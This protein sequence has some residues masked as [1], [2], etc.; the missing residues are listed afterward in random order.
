LKDSI[1]LEDDIELVA[2]NVNLGT[3]LFKVAQNDE[4][5]RLY[6]LALEL[7]ERQGKTKDNHPVAKRLHHSLQEKMYHKSVNFE[8]NE[9]LS[10]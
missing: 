5:V 7:L 2:A 3:E 4:A 8:S 1:L 6:S 9:R 10:E